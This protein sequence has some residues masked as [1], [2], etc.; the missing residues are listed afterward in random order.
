MPAGPVGKKRFTQTD[1]VFFDNEKHMTTAPAAYLSAR[2]AGRS[3]CPSRNPTR[4][5]RRPAKASRGQAGRKGPAAPFSA[6]LRSGV[7]WFYPA[8]PLMRGMLRPG[9][10][11]FRLT[12]MQGAAWMRLYSLCR[13]RRA[14]SC[15]SAG[16]SRS[17]AAMSAMSCR[18]ST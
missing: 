5:G 15:T 17:L 9:P 1:F 13:M 8:K 4:G 10:K 2:K 12:R 6:R 16:S 3:F 7:L 11:A 18:S 14:T